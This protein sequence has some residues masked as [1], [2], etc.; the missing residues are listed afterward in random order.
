VQNRPIGLF[1]SGV[2]GLSIFLEIK[3]ILPGEDMVYFADQANV[4]YGEKTAGKIREFSEKIIKFLVSQRAKMVVVAC[5]TASVYALDLVREKF[6]KLP[7]IGVVPIIKML[8]ELTKTRN[9]AVLTTPATAKSGYLKKLIKKYARQVKVFAIGLDGIEEQVEAGRLNDRSTITLL[10]KQLK[11]LRD[12]N[13]DYIGLGCTHYP[14]LKKQ[15]DK[16]IGG[17]IQILD[18]GEAIARRVTQLLTESENLAQTIAG[19]Y[20]FF[21]SGEQKQ[22]YQVASKLLRNQSIKV[23]KVTL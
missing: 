8:T 20:K 5:N 4:P 9:I 16:I 7:I 14:F 21:T 13:I 1:D 23:Y 11:P 15:I 3:R 2:G 6:P 12:K 17:N 10:E 18:S 19:Q 22:F